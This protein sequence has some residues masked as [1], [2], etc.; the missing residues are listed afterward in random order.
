MSG[1]AKIEA[2]TNAWYGYTLFAAL[3]NLVS[4]LLGSGLF[5]FLTVPFVIGVSLFSLFLTWGIGKLLLAR[6]GLT[7]FVLLV[8]SPLA[9]LFGSLSLWKF[10]TSPW[11]FGAITA[12]LITGCGVWMQLR[13]LR[14]LLDKSVK[15]YFA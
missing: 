9:I 2:L 8:L 13:S 11:S 4:A 14:T 12:A 7:R 15:S 6:S 1:K 5:A 3:V 10:A